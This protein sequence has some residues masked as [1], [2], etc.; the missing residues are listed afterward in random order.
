MDHAFGLDEHTDMESLQKAINKDTVLYSGVPLTNT[1]D[2]IGYVTKRAFGRGGE[3]RRGVA[4]VIIT[5]TDG[6]SQRPRY[7]ARK[8]A[9]ARQKGVYMFAVGVGNYTD[10]QELQV[11]NTFCS[12]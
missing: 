2:A 10:E 5:V 12:L 7:T 9:S 1:G 4:Q 3:A 11:R 6:L 8:A